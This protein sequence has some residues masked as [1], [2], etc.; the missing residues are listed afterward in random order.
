MRFELSVA[1]WGAGGRHRPQ[2]PAQSGLVVGLSVQVG[3]A[4]LDR[5]RAIRRACE[6]VGG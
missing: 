6:S 1:P 3:F 5:M 4:G 2:V